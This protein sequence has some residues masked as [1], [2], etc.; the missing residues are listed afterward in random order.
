MRW[1]VDLL[2]RGGCN[3]VLVVL[4]EG[5]EPPG[6]VSE[7]DVVSFTTG[8]PTRQD[9]VGNALELV[10]TP[11]VLVHDAV[12][13]LA[14]ASLLERV[15]GALHGVDGVIPAVPIDETI[16]RVESRV[17]VETVDRACLW[18]AQ[19]PAA[20]VTQSLQT[21]YER[22]RAEVFVGTDEAQLVLRYGGKV[23]V[24]PGN[25]ANIKVTFPEDLG[26]VG[27]LLGAMR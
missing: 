15:L 8:G 4:P 1:A 11:R 20:F 21:A 24:V 5:L 16:A 3:P 12:R 17:V 9:S 14:G 6:D 26:L 19:T 7:G 27:S 10:E 25:R 22:A 13:P 2:A 23:A 18:R